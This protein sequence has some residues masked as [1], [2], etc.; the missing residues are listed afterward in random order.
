MIPTAQECTPRRGAL[1]HPLEMPHTPDDPVEVLLLED[2]R[3]DAATLEREFGRTDLKVNVTVTEDLTAYSVAIRE[4][5]FDVVLLDYVIPGGDG[6]AACALLSGTPRN[7]DVPRVMI[8]NEVRHDMA[9]AALKSGCLDCLPKESLGP[10][11]LRDL[12]IRAVGARPRWTPHLL[13]E[14]RTLVR[15]ELASAGVPVDLSQLQFALAAIG[16]TAPPGHK[17]DWGSIFQEEETAFVFRK[18]TH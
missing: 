1:F 16:I 7:A 8:S 2:S 5:R 4:R 6:L 18:Q 13:N 10:D 14:I 15:E 9:V 12:L 17:S 3:F 11:M